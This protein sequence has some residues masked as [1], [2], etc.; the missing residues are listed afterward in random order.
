MTPVELR[1]K[2][3]IAAGSP[4]KVFYV[5]RALSVFEL[6]LCKSF[7]EDHISAHLMKAF[8]CRFSAEYHRFCRLPEVLCAAFSMLTVAVLTKQWMFWFSILVKYLHE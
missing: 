4:W 7:G 5:M 1:Y 8:L 2:S 6:R 3:L